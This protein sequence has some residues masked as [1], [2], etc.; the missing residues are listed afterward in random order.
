MFLGPETQLQWCKTILMFEPLELSLWAQEHILL[1]KSQN[2]AGA[3]G[4]RL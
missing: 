4:S 3:S 2:V 1:K